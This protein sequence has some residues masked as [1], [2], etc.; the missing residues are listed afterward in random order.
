MKKFFSLLATL[1]VLALAI[2]I[3]RTLWVHYMNTPW[4]RDGRVRADIINVAADVNG[5]VVNVPVKD[6]QLVKK[7][8]VLLEIDPEHYEIAVKQAQSLVASRKATWEMRKLNAHRRADMDNLVISKENRDDATNIADSALA[9][10]QHALAQ[11]DAA[12]LN[13]KRT[14]VLATVNGYVTNLNVHRGDYARVGDPKMAVVDKDSFWV[15]GFFEETKLPHIR[16]GDKAELQ[17]MSG[18]VLKGHV[19]SISRGIYDRDNPESRELVAD[20]NPTFN[21]VRLA[22]RVPVRIHIDEIPE[23]FLLAAGTTCTVIVQQDDVDTHPE[24]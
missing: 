2:W 24:H 18:E 15:Y 23:G 5:Y 22:Q 17:M 13:L 6:N 7:G 10:Y 3:G 19:E 9:D 4:T 8:D 1:L 14:K 11:L 12:L 21:W 20:V 16:V